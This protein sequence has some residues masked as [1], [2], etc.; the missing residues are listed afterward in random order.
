M[1]YDNIEDFFEL[2]MVV[3]IIYGSYKRKDM[4]QEIK[5]ETVEADIGIGESETWRWLN[6]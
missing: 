2:D 1:K 3:T 5:K 4:I 6:Q